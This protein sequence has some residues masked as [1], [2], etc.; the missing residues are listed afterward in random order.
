MR[1][2]DFCGDV[3][4]YKRI[5]FT[6]NIEIHCSTCGALM[7]YHACYEVTYKSNEIITKIIILR[8]K[9]KKCNVTHALKPEFL[10]SRH[11]YDTFQRQK[12]I[13]QYNDISKGP[14]S[15]RRLCCKLF[16]SLPVSHTVMYYWVRVVTTKKAVIEP[17]I[18]KEIQEY[19]PSCD[20]SSELL[21]EAEAIPSWI[22]NKE[23]SKDVTKIINWSRIYIRT[24]AAFRDNKISDLNIRPF[25]YINRI[26]DILT[27][28]VFL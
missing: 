5:I 10:A 22:R 13:L 23:Y 14:I 11:Q 19:S 8:Y 27:A 12:Y 17:L 25:I 26:L 2:L 15:L 16:P 4:A 9:C 28:H 20:I 3:N 21:P 1:L 7:V 18:T 24:T 6:I